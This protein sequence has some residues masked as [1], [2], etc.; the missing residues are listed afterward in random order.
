MA[1]LSLLVIPDGEA[2]GATPLIS[3]WIGTA[4][5]DQDPILIRGGHGRHAARGRRGHVR[6]HSHHHRLRAGH[7]RRAFRS[8]SRSTGNSHE[9]ATA[10]S[11]GAGPI[12]G[13]SIRTAEVQVPHQVASASEPIAGIDVNR[14]KAL[15]CE[16][17]RRVVS[18][19]AFST[20]SP[21]SCSGPIYAFQASRADST[22]AVLLS[23]SSGEILK[24]QKLPG[25][26]PSQPSGPLLVN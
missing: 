1:G 23:A 25:S 19:Y 17:A 10:A 2:L 14:I 26:A 11:F 4:L 16:A 9:A 13:A 12:F 3:S 15:D 21:T 22:Y 8:G 24:V 6:G 18:G 7:V 20:V 5:I